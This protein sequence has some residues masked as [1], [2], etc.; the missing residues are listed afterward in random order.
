MYKSVAVLGLILLGSVHFVSA[1]ESPDSTSL[2][3]IKKSDIPLHISLDKG[4]KIAT[5]DDSFAMHI[6]FRI[7]NRLGFGVVEDGEKL[8]FTAVEARARR[9]RLRLDGHLL[10]KRLEYHL[11]LSFA[12]ADM[13][14]DNSGVPNV[15]RDAYFIYKLTPKLDITFGQ[16]KL[17]GNRQRV[18]S[19]GD[20]QFVDRSIVNAT[21]NIDRDFGVMFKYK[22][23]LGIDYVVKGALS[24]GEGRNS[25]I[26]NGGVCYSGRLELLPLG[27]FT[28][29]SD[30]YESDLAREPKPKLAI[31]GGMSFNDQA[32]RT[33][34]Q[35]G[36]DVK[37]PVEIIVYHADALLKYKGFS[38]YSEAMKRTASN[39]IP[40][41]T[42]PKNF[43]YSGTGVMSQM[44]YLWKS[45]YELALRAATV[46]PDS[47][48]IMLATKV[49]NFT[50][51]VSKYIRK[52]SI[53]VQSDL[54][55][56]TV[57][58]LSTKQF[59]STGVYFRLQLQ[60]AI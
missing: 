35:L 17:P 46:K 60:L 10:T 30:Y 20:Q 24:N 26:G 55:Y 3:L 38:W 9:V 25:N 7:Q 42:A 41:A 15:L 8:D 32:V 11:Q 45:N 53:K 57:Q 34:G 4:V 48:I 54:T 33:A 16:T 43:I 40:D 51:C 58:D 52:H 13:D 37:T 36:K 14:W 31:A 44:G 49:D 19:S 39:N 1:Q 29:G 27:H 2:F 56:E 23:K 21:Y 18:I 5:A 47:E 59:K 28:D 50:L 6:R 22:G 12:R